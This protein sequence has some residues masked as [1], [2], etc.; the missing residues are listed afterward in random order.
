MRKTLLSIALT[1]G[2]ISTFWAQY[3]HDFCP[4]QDEE[5]PFDIDKILHQTSVQNN[6]PIIPGYIGFTASTDQSV[7]IATENI[8]EI[9]E[10]SE[11]INLSITMEEML[12][13]QAKEEAQQETFN[14]IE[15]E[16][17]FLTDDLEEEIEDDFDEDFDEDEALDGKDEKENLINRK[18]SKHKKKFRVKKHKR[19][20][21]YA[22]KCPKFW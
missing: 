1:I 12:I 21:K 9:E 16:D 11:R 14:L 20:K 19:T 18:R 6:A 15:E 5:T 7:S 2:F 8:F 13:Q 22:D 4:C 3:N 10:K 17:D